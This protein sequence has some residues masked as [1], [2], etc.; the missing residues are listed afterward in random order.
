MDPAH[1]LVTP[2]A[3]GPRPGTMTVRAEAQRPDFDRLP[4]WYHARAWA[5][6]LIAASAACRNATLSVGKASRR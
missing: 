6:S 4:Y 3:V 1:D 5:G 2:L